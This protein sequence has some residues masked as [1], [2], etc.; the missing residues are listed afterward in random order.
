MQFVG[1]LFQSQIKFQC[2][3]IDE[4]I[5]LY[6]IAENSFSRG[7][8]YLLLQCNTKFRFCIQNSGFE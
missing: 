7:F 6:K 4:C 3:L 8:T 5:Y 2:N 1:L